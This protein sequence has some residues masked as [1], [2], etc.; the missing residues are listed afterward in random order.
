[1][2]S[3][4]PHPIHSTLFPS[5]LVQTW[6][7]WCLTHPPPP[8]HSTPPTLCIS[9]P[10]KD[11]HLCQP[12]LQQGPHW[13][14]FLDI[15][16]RRRGLVPRSPCVYTHTQEQAVTEWMRE[17]Q[18][19]WGSVASLPRILPSHS[20]A[21]T[22]VFFHG[23]TEQVFLPSIQ[24]VLIKALTA[25]T[26]GLAACSGFC[27]CK[28]SAGAQT[29]PAVCLPAEQTLSLDDQKAQLSPLIYFCSH[30]WFCAEMPELSYSISVSWMFFQVRRGWG[31]RWVGETASSSHVAPFVNELW[32]SW[33][34]G[35]WDSLCET[36]VR[37]V[38]CLGAAY[39]QVK[40][41]MHLSVSN[42]QH[43]S[44]VCDATH[45]CAFQRL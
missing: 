40:S 11:L 41:V 22:L 14:L 15:F 16:G 8:I 10:M 43:L 25:L 44:C 21:S 42:H 45:K 9:W 7:T 18:D 24:L 32:M 28:Q 38:D 13:L 30:A 20:Y 37:F 39:L 29:V 2:K 34:T 36:P 26:S 3:P 6:C 5:Y 19:E 1:M 33:T 4:P 27:S 31:M 17:S 23:P 12:L 35:G